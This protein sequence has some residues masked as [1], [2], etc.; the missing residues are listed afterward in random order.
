MQDTII[1]AVAQE[2]HLAPA[3][4][5]DLFDQF[6]NGVSLPYLARYRKDLV[7]SLSYMDLKGLLERR[8]D[9]RKIEKRK[10]EVLK[11][12]K[13]RELLT[14]ELEQTIEQATSIRVV[15]DIFLP[16]RPK[17]HSRAV[18]AMAL[19]LE[20]AARRL[21]E[22][23]EPGLRPAEVAQ[24]LVDA[25]KGLPDVAAVLKGCAYIICDWIAEERTLRDTQRQ[26]LRREGRIQLRQ[27]RK[28]GQDRL[29]R[30]FRDLASL[31]DK[32][33]SLNP[34]RALL[35]A[36]ACKQR[37]FDFGLL[38]PM[39]MM[40][41]AT[42]ELYL[43]GGKDALATLL[44]VRPEDPLAQ[45][46]HIGVG[47]DQTGEGQKS[48][49]H[50][51]ALTQ[52]FP[53]VQPDISLPAFLL[54][55]IEWSLQHILAP[56]LVREIERELEDQAEKH[57][58]GI[59]RRNLRAVLMQQPLGV[60]PILAISP[61][62]RTGCKLAVLDAKGAVLE[63]Q[64]V[65]PHTPKNEVEQSV[66][67]IEELVKKHGISVV[68][69]GDGTACRET[70]ALISQMIQEKLPDLSYSIASEAGVPA[71]VTSK[72]AKQELTGMPQTVK[73]AV[74]LGRRVLDP[75]KELVK[76]E[77][78]ALCTSPHLQVISSRIVK[79]V[80]TEIVEE[81]VC[82]VGVDLN[83]TDINLLRCVPGMNGN[84]ARTVL[85]KREQ[86]GRFTSRSQLMEVEGMDAAVYTQCAGFLR[87]TGGSEILDSTRIHPDQYGVARAIC[88]EIGIEPAKMYEAETHAKL[89]EARKQLNLV[90]LASK[91]DLTHL[92][93]RDILAEL[94]DPWSDPRAAF[95]KPMLRKTQLK[96]DD[97]K[98]GDM[99]Q[100]V[101]RNIVDFGV[102]VDVGVNEDGLVHVSELSDEYVHSPYEV[103]STGDILSVRVLKVD[104]ASGRIALSCRKQGER[105]RGRQRP[106]RRAG[107]E[108]PQRPPRPA[109]SEAPAAA[110]PKT[111]PAAPPKPAAAPKPA[112]TPVA[113][114]PARPQKAAPVQVPQST[115]G[116]QSR[117]VQKASRDHPLS[118]TE[119]QIL[120]APKPESK[121]EK[122]G[123]DEG[124]AGLL[125]GLQFGTVEK[126]GKKDED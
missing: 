121:E 20:P 124:V 70:E 102:F 60:S 81:C 18:E 66:A 111:A 78:K 105:P 71:Y 15:N 46:M 1:D 43:D 91:Y 51:V 116:A 47:P 126:R 37:V 53:D 62:Y 9:I 104:H 16:Y 63:N 26:I 38:A 100:G 118:K 68:V 92:A 57:A 5:K 95:P 28:G 61:G 125:G 101:V 115:L 117:R 11:K 113:D 50:E 39:A 80:L 88:Q 99:L 108:Q 107:A 10:R 42:A 112:G 90:T 27:S 82:E 109:K 77:P 45:P 85:A 7:G 30:E 24:P 76:L 13:E 87:V 96:L 114:K 55:C 8:R 56:V 79:D 123:K 89:E 106:P 22:Q 58:I 36:R 3:Q 98:P 69:I 23:N 97:I 120:K 34:Y 49:D 93:V 94:A 35:V 48:E 119:R 59:V 110:A 86:L 33:Q 14:P 75:L 21:L 103:V 12:L 6:E 54:S 17:K 2:F 41:E 73:S 84:R 83:D 64:I 19:G 31:D 67:V 44:A 74:S 29:G 32:V 52:E 4:V 122:K 72:L 25:A 65:Y 40:R